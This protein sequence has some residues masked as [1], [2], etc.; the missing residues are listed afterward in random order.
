MTA[1]TFTLT[2]PRCGHDVEAV[3]NDDPKG[4]VTRERRLVVCC[5][6][7]WCAWSGVVIAELVDINAKRGAA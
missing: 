6:K 3:A 5:L 2:C 4:W 1:V 7:P